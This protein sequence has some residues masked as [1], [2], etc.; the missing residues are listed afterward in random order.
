MSRVPAIAIDGP[1]ASGKTV[2]GL[3]LARRLGY[4]FIDTGAMYRAVTLL[5]LERRIAL[6]DHEALADLAAGL[7]MEFRDAA[8]A[9][10][11]PRLLVDGRD[12][13][14]EVHGPAVDRAVSQVS[15]VRGVRQAMVRLQ[16]AL[17]A[18]GPV[19][20]AGRDI[21]TVVLPEAGL[22]VFLVA[23]P[24]IRARRRYEELRARGVAIEYQAVLEDLKRRDQMDIERALSPLAPAQ[25]ARQIDTDGS[26]IGEIVERIWQLTERPSGPSTSP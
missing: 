6:D 1:G 4:R 24:E 10:G 20:M 5:A 16:R 3:A 8:R 21:G 15:M 9:D 7:S 18:R 26:T 17:A 22:K 14:E 13:S 12:L 23:S 2:V 19:V 11:L 25:D